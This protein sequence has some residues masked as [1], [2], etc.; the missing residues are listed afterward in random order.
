[1]NQI[2]SP[3]ARQSCRRSPRRPR[4][5]RDSLVR[6]ALRI[7]GNLNQ[8]NEHHGGHGPPDAAALLEACDAVRDR[9][10]HLSRARYRGWR[11]AE[12]R[13]REELLRDCRELQSAATQ[14]L[15]RSSQSHRPGPLEVL[16]ELRQLH[17]EFEAVE[18]DLKEGVL[19]ATTEPVELEDT[20]LGR[21][22]IRLH[23]PR[24]ADRPD[25]SCFDCVALDPNPAHSS[26][27]V[28][29]PHVQDWQLCSGEAS[30][31]IVEALAQ[32][33]VCDAFVLVRSVLNTYNAS[34]A[35]VALDE[36]D[37]VTCGECGHSYSPDDGRY[38][39]HCCCDYCD[40]CTG[41]CE[42][43]DG[44]CCRSCL[45]LDEEVGVYCCPDCRGTC[46]GCSRVVLN[47]HVDEATGLCPQCLKARTEGQVG[48]ETESLADAPTEAMPVA[49]PTP[50]PMP[51]TGSVTGP[52]TTC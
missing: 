4:G 14:L 30:A 45:G 7:A 27:S 11:L 34:S 20:H 6:A 52:M 25:A 44:T 19:S 49:A 5:C 31:P 1:M 33:R 50:V 40:E 18:L 39:E 10:R 28:T 12:R 35:Y 36:W 38:C 21:F 24:L 29:H 37:G 48:G 43:C 46:A 32:G 13:L 9:C 3:P 16:G 26:P 8:T 51:A 15:S 47:K 41:C 23:L 42:A 17:E 22:S 2:V